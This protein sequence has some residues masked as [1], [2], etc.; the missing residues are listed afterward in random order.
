MPRCQLMSSR[1][2][3]TNIPGTLLNFWENFKKETHSVTL[4][5]CLILQLRT[6]WIYLPEQGRGSYSSIN[7]TLFLFS[8][9]IQIFWA[10][11]SFTSLPLLLGWGLGSPRPTSAEICLCSSSSAHL[12]LR[13]LFSL[14]LLLASLAFT[15][16]SCKTFYFTSVELNA[17]NVHTIQDTS[18]LL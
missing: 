13:V 12:G 2:T 11:S 15:F 1:M 9:L 6:G 18:M 14:V 17:A 4:E 5:F 8:P 3:C 16:P 10:Y 7:F